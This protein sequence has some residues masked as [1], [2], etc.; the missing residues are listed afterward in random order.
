[1]VG[2][3]L[4]SHVP[5]P[6]VTLGPGNRFVKQT[7]QFYHYPLTV[8]ETMP[9]RGEGTCSRLHSNGVSGWL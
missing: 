1:M 6:A 3:R 9:Q 5:I 2:S 7:E 4:S 8:K